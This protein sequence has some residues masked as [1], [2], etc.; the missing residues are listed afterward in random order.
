MAD[1]DEIL[2]RVYDDLRAVADRYLRNERSG[3]TLQTTALVHEAYLRLA[4]QSG[5]NWQEEAHVVAIAAQAMRRVLVD[6]ARGRGRIKRG[7]DRLRVT[8]S[9]AAVELADREVDLLALDEALAKLAE[10]DARK[11][12]VV[13]LR[14]FGG[15]TVA[16]IGSVVSRSERV[17]ADDLAVARAW[18]RKEMRGG[19]K[20]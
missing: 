11:A 8:L 4:D 20:P 5:A 6:H 1:L 16:Q 10:F 9:E 14:Y 12:T 7:G 2:P 3:H 19:T 15:L 13:E 17:V 18:L